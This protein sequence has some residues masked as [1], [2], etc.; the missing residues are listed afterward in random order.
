LQTFVVSQAVCANMNLLY[1][2]NDCNFRLLQ[3]CKEDY[4]HIMQLRSVVTD[5][6]E[7][8]ISTILNVRPSMMA[9]IGCQK[10]SVTNYQYRPCNIPEEWGSLE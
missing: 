8:P 9:L 3:W 6:L 2:W 10:M 1:N 5:V 4:W 7:Q